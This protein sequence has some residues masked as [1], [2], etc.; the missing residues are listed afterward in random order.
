MVHDSIYTVRPANA[1][2]KYIQQL[3]KRSTP[4]WFYQT[5]NGE[6]LLRAMEKAVMRMPMC[7]RDPCMSSSIPTDS[8]PYQYACSAEHLYQT[9]MDFN[10]YSNSST[11]LQC[12]ERFHDRIDDLLTL[13]MAVSH[14]FYY[15]FTF[16]YW[17]LEYDSVSIRDNEPV[18][19]HKIRTEKK[20]NKPLEHYNLA[21]ME[22]YLRLYR[23]IRPNYHIR[24]SRV[25]FIIDLDKHYPAEIWDC[26]FKILQCVSN[27]ICSLQPYFGDDPFNKAFLTRY[28][29]WADH[30]ISIGYPIGEAT[31]M[32]EAIVESTTDCVIDTYDDDRH[33]FMASYHRG[34]LTDE[35]IDPHQFIVLAQTY[36]LTVIRQNAL[37]G[38]YIH[39]ERT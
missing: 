5:F 32:L 36:P 2:Q 22:M 12:Q 27:A 34:F 15:D 28:F 29:H 37:S 38:D 6:D 9:M 39:Q 18:I 30:L 8:F 35:V 10:R 17:N 14:G 16:R 3:M 31:L 11:L 26:A 19:K 20:R 1:L 13:V 24:R 7:Q 4:Q 33:G 25:P 21:T 23:F